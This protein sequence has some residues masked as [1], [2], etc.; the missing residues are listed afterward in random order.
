M[1]NLNNT[2]SAKYGCSPQQIEEQ[3]LDPKTGKY[4]QEVYNF[5]WL[6][7]VKK[8]RDQSETFDT[9]VDRCKKRLR[10]PL[11]INKKVLALAERL[12]KKDTPRR[13]YKSTTEKKTFFKR[14]KIFT[15]SARLKLNNGT[16]LYWL[17]ENGRKTKGIFLRQEL[18][19]LK[20][21]FVE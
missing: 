18:F 17:N 1:F 21:Q 6:M 7:K 11:D 4:F 10:E 2:T 12:R 19:A 3:A 5:D 13:L 9:K 15:I 8:N 14:D 16:Y 20:N